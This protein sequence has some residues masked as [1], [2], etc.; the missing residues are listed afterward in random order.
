MT[1]QCDNGYCLLRLEGTEESF[2][3]VRKL[4]EE[5]R[6]IH[7]DPRWY[8]PDVIDE[9]SWLW[10]GFDPEHPQNI[11]SEAMDN[12]SHTEFE[13][14]LR[15]LLKIAP[16]LGFTG[17]SSHDWLGFLGPADVVTYESKPGSNCMTACEP[18][19]PDRIIEV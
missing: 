19:R 12:G 15:D 17:E 9:M 13:Y 16:E 1:R 6:R 3:K 8:E 2:D 10:D 7:M 4:V 5:K 18:S 14:F 11:Y